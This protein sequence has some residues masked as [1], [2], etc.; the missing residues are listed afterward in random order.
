MWPYRFAIRTVV[1][2]LQP[3]IAAT[4]ENGA[5]AS[6]I[7]VQAV[8]RRSWKRHCTPARFFAAS[9]ASPTANRLCGIGAVHAGSFEAVSRRP[10][11][12][13][14]EDVVLRLAQRK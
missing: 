2:A 7:R 14:R 8:W 10:V 12:L 6:S 3:M 13:G 4:T 5:P 11:S 9:Q 1:E